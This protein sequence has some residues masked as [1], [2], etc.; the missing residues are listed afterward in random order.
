MIPRLKEKYN[1]ELSGEIQKELNLSNIN[2]IPTLEKIIINI[3][4]GKAATDGRA[5]ESMVDELTAISGQKPVVKRAKKSI[6]G[7]KIREGM[8]IGTSVTIRGDR[9]WEFYDRF[10]QVVVPRIRDFRGFSTKSFD[11]KGNYSLGLNE[12]LVFPE[13]EYDKVRDIRGMNITIC[14]TAND[15]N[16]GYVLLNSL[17]FPFRE[18]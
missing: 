16:E 3:G 12:Q 15:N 8:P 17:G 10:V 18:N 9:M 2:Q 1:L 14:T 5:L 13:V 11:G 7:F 4:D 6:A